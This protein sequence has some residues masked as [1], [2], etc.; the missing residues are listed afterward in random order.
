MGKYDYLLEN[1]IL[2]P[3]DVVVVKYLGDRRTIWVDA[4]EWFENGDVS[5]VF[6][7]LGGGTGQI[8]DVKFKT[9]VTIGNIRDYFR[10]DVE[11]TIRRYKP[12][13]VEQME[14][15]KSSAYSMVGKN[16]DTFSII[17]AAVRAL[18]RKIGWYEKMKEWFLWIESPAKVHCSEC[19]T[20]LF[21]TIKVG[22][23]NR[24]PEDVTPQVILET[25]MLET[26]G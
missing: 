4:I 25:P 12:L 13:T 5:H 26:L 21:L 24:N 7:Y 8:L 20:R 18:L 10:D 2:A 15:M 16:Y 14:Q 22:I 1:H 19:V 17:K 6:T 9:G 11:L 23:S 3:C